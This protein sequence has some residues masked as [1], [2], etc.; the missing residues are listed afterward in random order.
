MREGDRRQSALKLPSFA[1]IAPFCV[2][3][4]D[5]GDMFH[6]RSRRGRGEPTWGRGGREGSGPGAAW[7]WLGVFAF[8]FL[9]SR[10]RSLGS[11]LATLGFGH[12]LETAL[13]TDLTAFAPNSGHVLGEVR[14]NCGAA[15]G[16]RVQVVF[17]LWRL[18]SRTIYNPLGKLVR[19]AWPL[20]LPNRHG[21]P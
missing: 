4:C 6:A 14:R 21:Q 15:T 3:L 8:R 20:S 18:A 11:N 19:I 7:L 13:P 17:W 2:Q 1:K 5:D 9:P 16:R 10:F 12:G